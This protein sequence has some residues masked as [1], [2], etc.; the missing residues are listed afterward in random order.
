MK[1]PYLNK[2]GFNKLAQSIKDYVNRKITGY[3]KL[4]TAS[5]KD[6][7][8]YVSPTQT[9][10][11]PISSS[12]YSAMTN[13]LR[14]AYHPA[15]SK[16]VAELTSD[17]LVKANLGNVYKITE[18]GVTSDLFI[19]G[20]GQT[21][22][23]G[24]NAVV[25]YASEDT[26]KFSLES[27][28]VDLDAYQ[29]KELTSA[30]GNETTVEAAISKNADD[31]SDIQDVIPSNASARNK[32][33]TAQE[34][35]VFARQESAGW[36]YYKLSDFFT[37]TTSPDNHLEF[38]ICGNASYAQLEWALVDA[39]FRF[40]AWYLGPNPW[41]FSRDGND[42]YISVCNYPFKIQRKTILGEA[43]E[44]TATP[45]TSVPSTA[46][47][48][49]TQK[50]I[51]REDLTSSVTSGST[52]PVTSGGVYAAMQPFT[53]LRLSKSNLTQ[54]V[55]FGAWGVGLCIGNIDGAGNFAFWFSRSVALS[56]KNV[57]TALG[58]QMQVASMDNSDIV[59]GT[60]SY[61]IRITI[62]SN[63]TLV[64]KNDG[65]NKNILIRGCVVCGSTAL[66]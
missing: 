37:Y 63:N 64:F 9:E 32:L 60:D 42:L 4:G 25:L 5:T 59:V 45:V 7:T 16:T 44:A 22:K 28:I 41:T 33:V 31:I 39:T 36:T 2:A 6:V 66:A 49:L 34:Y 51:L 15:G 58:L 3:D 50:I 12:V 27:G 65:S 11:L 57:D 8:T 61:R 13:M 17:L 18:D 55:P 23:T 52:A 53:K 48:I 38:F 47:E 40:R 30:I 56:V 20:A 10:Q 1:R 62:G 19:G 29:K 26:Y 21:I 24:D 54:A 46:V 14:G 43:N 35:Q